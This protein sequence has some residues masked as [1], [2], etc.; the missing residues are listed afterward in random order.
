MAQGKL[1]I[2]SGYPGSGKDTAV[3][4]IL[5]KKKLGF[6]RIVTHNTRSIRKGEK[7]GREYFFVT[8][9]EFKALIKSGQMVEYVYHGFCFKGTTA[10][11]FQR[12][13]TGE[14]LIWRINPGRAAFAE[15]FFLEKFGKKEGKKIVDS[16]VKLFISVDDP[17]ILLERYKGREKD[18][19]NVKEFE[20][21]LKQ[22][23]EVF[24]KNR[25]RFGNIVKNDGSAEEFK[26]KILDLI[27]NKLVI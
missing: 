5:S 16:I 9:R 22:D 17:N 24:E 12:I 27:N 23:V 4:D 3:E 2:I 25:H 7:Q 1:L 13:L 8:K 21:R 6:K 10:D 15:E 26:D 18:T 19:Y 20:K 11:Q 14:N